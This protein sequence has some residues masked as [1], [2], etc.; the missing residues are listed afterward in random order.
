MRIIII[1][2]IL[3]YKIQFFEL[4]DLSIDDL[5]RSLKPMLNCKEEIL[6]IAIIVET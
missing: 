1:Y 3:S 2:N 4:F 5:Y 6:K